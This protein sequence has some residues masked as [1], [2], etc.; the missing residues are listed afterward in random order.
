MAKKK[1][2]RKAKANKRAVGL[3]ILVTALLAILLGVGIV[4]M[5]IDRDK[6]EAYLQ[7]LEESVAYESVRQE[8]LAAAD[9]AELTDE[10]IIRIAREKF[11]LVFPEDIIFR[12]ENE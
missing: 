4:M 3:L 10:D 5:K 11:G 7:K 12:P 6:E 9:G 8:I 1:S 2:I